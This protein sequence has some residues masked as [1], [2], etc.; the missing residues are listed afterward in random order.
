VEAGKLLFPVEELAVIPSSLPRLR[1][2][3]KELSQP[4]RKTNVVSVKLIVDKKPPGTKSPNLGDAFVS[5]F[6]P[7]ESESYDSSMEW[8]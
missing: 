4:R 5:C 7:V 1:T 8:L 2:L 6:F 3:Q